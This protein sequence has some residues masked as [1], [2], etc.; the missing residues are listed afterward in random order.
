MDLSYICNINIWSSSIVWIKL[1][2]II[3]LKLI[4]G[5]A[6]NPPIHIKSSLLKLFKANF[7]APSFKK[8][9]L[10]PFDFKKLGKPNIALLP[11]PK[12]EAPPGIK[13]VQNLIN[14]FTYW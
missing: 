13:A 3:S 5:N 14:C 1:F 6:D 10:S 7:S 9:F 4:N 8:N 11:K 12:V 2:F